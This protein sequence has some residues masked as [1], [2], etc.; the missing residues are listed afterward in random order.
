MTNTTVKIDL[1]MISLILIVQRCIE[2]I[3]NFNRMLKAILYLT[4]NELNNMKTRLLF[5]DI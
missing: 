1:F 4:Y 5:Y 3:A 2:R